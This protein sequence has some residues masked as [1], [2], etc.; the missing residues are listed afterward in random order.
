MLRTVF[1]GGVIWVSL[2]FSVVVA[3][4]A[5][6][7]VAPSRSEPWSVLCFVAVFV[8]AELPVHMAVVVLVGATAF[9][10][11]VSDHNWAWWMAL[12][13]CASAA[14]AYAFLAVVAH[15]SGRLTQDSLDDAARGPIVAPG[16]DLR[17]AWGSWWRLV[18][19]LPLS[20]R[21]IRR[22]RGVDY[23][24]TGI[25]R[26]T[27]DVL[28]RRAD[29]PTGAPVLV[30]IHG[31]AW[32]IG[33]KREQGIPMMHELAQR[34]WVCVA[35]NYRLS[36]K[37]TWPDHVVDCKRALAWVREHIAEYGGDPSFVAVSGGSAGGHLA[38]LV[39]VTPNE[40]EWQPGF[41]EADTSVDACIPFYGVHDVTGHP[42]ASGTHGPGLVDLLQ[43]RVMKTTVHVDRDTFDLASPDQRITSA[44]PPMFVI[45]GANDTLMP[46]EVGRRFADRLREVSE[47]PVAYL[48]LPYTQ[49]AFDI[50]VSIRSRH[51]TQGVVRFLEG[52]RSRATS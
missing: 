48:E 52:I 40:P 42:E 10:T 2:A 13:L 49:H 37:A 45:Q 38:A 5:L 24:G 9:A 32:V 14:V 17:P 47:A 35:I 25:H 36:P 7:I 51:T 20:P 18:L 30:Y 44:A 4:V 27:L 16:V 1:D 6:M 29:P 23:A 39:A 33:D 41:E 8:V 11:G 43:E 34:G 21:R 19:A 28:V 22:I 3:L 12:A 31:G 50:L 15:R 46:R 26:N